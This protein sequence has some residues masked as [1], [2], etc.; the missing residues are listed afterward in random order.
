M[1]PEQAAQASAAMFAEHMKTMNAITERGTR[2]SQ[3][4]TA[5][6]LRICDRVQDSGRVIAGVIHAEREAV[7]ADLDRQSKDGVS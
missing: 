5:T 2:E 6:C 4:W 1:T 3:A 7:R